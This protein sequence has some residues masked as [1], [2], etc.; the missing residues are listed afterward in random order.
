MKKQSF[1]RRIKPN[2]NPN[3]ATYR[4]FKH[5]FLNNLCSDKIEHQIKNVNELKTENKNSST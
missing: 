5:D 3:D 4:D 2:M 1:Y